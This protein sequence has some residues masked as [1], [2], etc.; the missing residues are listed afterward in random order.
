L[1]TV[2]RYDRAC[3]WHV[4]VISHVNV[5]GA[6]EKLRLRLIIKVLFLNLLVGKFC[7]CAD[8]CILGQW[9]TTS[10]NSLYTLTLLLTAVGLI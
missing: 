9:I 7:D 8:R 10:P 3:E 4:L 1:Y 6:I 2:G 5:H